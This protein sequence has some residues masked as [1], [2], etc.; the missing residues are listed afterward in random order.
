MLKQGDFVEKSI[1]G[2]LFIQCARVTLNIKSF[3]LG[4]RPEIYSF[5]SGAL[6]WL[7]FLNVTQTRKYCILLFC[8]CFE[9]IIF[10]DIYKFM[11]V[12]Q[13]YNDPEKL[14]IFLSQFHSQDGAKDAKMWKV[15]GI[16][17][18]TRNVTRV[19]YDAPSERV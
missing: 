15:V 14:R 5:V 7:I 17:C 16:P 9:V 4:L 12:H 19:G 8:S 10:S 11:F 2:H 6:P 3:F 1:N 13:T 18:T